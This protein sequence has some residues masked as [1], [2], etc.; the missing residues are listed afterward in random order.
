MITLKRY[1][2]T[3]VALLAMTAGAWAQSTDPVVTY[4]DAKTTA[5]FPMPAFDATV[6]YQLVRDLAQG[7]AFSG[8]PEGDGRILKKDGDK[9]TFATAP[10][11]ALE[12]NISGTAQAITAEGD[13][14]SV[15]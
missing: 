13:R 9:Y 10:T 12:D 7:V 6:S 15:V 5:S 11:I 14:K 1:L 4:N 8:L 2:L 3:L